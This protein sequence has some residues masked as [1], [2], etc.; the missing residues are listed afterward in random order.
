[1]SGWVGRWMDEGVALWS[2]RAKLLYPKSLKHLQKESSRCPQAQI[3]SLLIHTFP[4]LLLSPLSPPSSCLAS[5][6]ICSLLSW[7]LH[8]APECSDAQ[9]VAYSSTILVSW[10]KM[11]TDI[12]S[13]TETRLDKECRG[14]KA[15]DLLCMS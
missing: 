15:A 14:E 3:E 12:P 5:C 4:S 8:L 1:M 13:P 6:Q 10:A 2:K 9:P 7:A 11:N